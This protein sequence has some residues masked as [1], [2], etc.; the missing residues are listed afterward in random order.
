MAAIPSNI[1]PQLQRISDAL[2]ERL[3]DE[4]ITQGHKLTG[5]L[6]ESIETKINEILGGFEITGEM[7]RYAT[8]VNNGVVASRIPY[9]GQRGLGG[10]S[11]YIQALIRFATLRGMDNPKS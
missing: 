5:R 8:F 10:K 1:I 11:K 9:S 3:Q 2:R 7:L 4:L 6:G